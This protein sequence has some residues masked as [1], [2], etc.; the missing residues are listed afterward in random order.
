MS[1]SIIEQLRKDLSSNNINQY[2]STTFADK[3]INST[4]NSIYEVMPSAIFSPTN[5]NDIEK[6]CQ[7]IN[8]DKYSEIDLIARGGGT[9]TNGQ[10]LG[11]GIIIDTFK[12]NKISQL[13]LVNKTVK[14]E[15]GVVLKD[16][17][18]YL[19]PHGLF[20]APNVSTENRATIGGMIAND[21][22]GKGSLIYGKTNHHV[23]DC[24]CVLIN[25]DVVNNTT[26]KQHSLFLKLA[27]ISKY[28]KQN[29]IL[30]DE[31]FK[32]IARPLSG[33]NLKYAFIDDDIDLVKL[34]SGSEGTLAI[35][36]DA[37]LKLLPIPKYK[38][39]IVSHYHTFL[40]ALDDAK[41]LIK[42]QPNTI[43]TIDEKVQKCASILPIWPDIAKLLDISSSDNYI[44]NFIELD[45][46]D[47]LLLINKLQEIQKDLQQRNIKY[48]VIDNNL[49]DIAK[50]WSI[51]SMAVGLAG[52]IALDKKPIAFVE[53]ALVPPIHLKDFVKEFQ[54]L[55]E[56]YNL[57]YAMYGHSD[58]GCIHVRPLIDLTNDDE[59]KLIRIISDKVVALAKKYH[60]ILWGEHGKGYRG[61]YI[62][63]IFG[64]ELYQIMCDIKTIFDP[65]NQLNRGKL[66]VSKL[67][68]HHVVKIDQIE[69]RGNLDRVISSKDIDYYNDAII[70]N[71]NALCFNHDN[72]N[73]MCPSYKVTANR[74]ESPK[75]RAMLVKQWLRSVANYGITHQNT[76]NVA[77]IAKNALDSCLGCKG[78][79]AKCPTGVSIPDMRSKFYNKFYNTYKKRTL[80]DLIL[81]HIESIILFGAKSYKLFNLLNKLA[82]VCSFGIINRPNLTHGN[83]ILKQLE[84]CGA[85]IYNV[86]EQSQIT[87]GL[88]IYI[89]CDVFTTYIDNDI[90]FSSVKLFTKL[91][92]QVIVIPP[93]NTGKALLVSGML[94]N[95]S[96]VAKKN[97]L[98]L[99]QIKS[100]DNNANIVALD[101]VITL[102]YRDDYPKF[103]NALPLKINT[104]AEVLNKIDWSMLNGSQKN[105]TMQL[106]LHCTEQSNK[107]DEG[108]LWKNIFTKLG[109]TLDIIDTGCCG[110]AGSYGHL[111]QYQTNSQ[112]LFNI[113]WDKF[114]SDDCMATG[115]SCRT[116]IKLQKK[117]VA[118]HPIKKILEIIE[119]I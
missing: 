119:A 64:D 26:F 77:T 22:A 17:N 28:I 20:F 8:Q 100:M 39:L 92:Y 104:I 105:I 73:T 117:Q 21:S 52:K 74:I 35:L 12:L 5:I 19:K 99:S 46:D 87:S 90:L 86:K 116:Q 88:H 63:Q 45:E 30:I 72:T 25:G 62:P 95:F 50:L 94:D 93:I 107:P 15:A 108:R 102:S 10:A 16:L 115:Y 40:D 118:I 14:V 96:A 109:Y 61:E 9:G 58:V 55:L 91:G 51:R 23:L 2:F 110:M 98:L 1:I 7:I 54:Q 43:E 32:P 101:N 47:Q 33:Y 3:I 56:S 80:Q 57:E 113:H 60:G 38:A 114:V 83:N 79:S 44:S 36:Y 78:C 24:N 48:V 31:V 66:V 70:C 4:D 13:D 67:K 71:G 89:L 85:L 59:V 37:T 34:I 68:S 103:A 84:S 112:K 49:Q 69:L 82:G 65:N 106:I 42:Y 97:H 27:T 53:D 6:L 75:G 41:N 11:S 111:S 29:Q 81:A 18:D 76:I